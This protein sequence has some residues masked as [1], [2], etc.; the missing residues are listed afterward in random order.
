MNEFPFHV[1]FDAEHAVDSGG[2]ARDM[3]SGFWLCAFDKFFDGSGSLVPATHP[4]IDVSVFL[5]LG[6]ILSHG[7]IACGFLSVHLS[8]PVIAAVLLGPDVQISDT[9]LCLQP[10]FHQQQDHLQ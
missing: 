10:S 2:V 8:F 6:K 1:S 9:V 3:F 4:T 7:Y 5:M